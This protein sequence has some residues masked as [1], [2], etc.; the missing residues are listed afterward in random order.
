VSVAVGL[1]SFVPPSVIFTAYYIVWLMMTCVARAFAKSDLPSFQNIYNYRLS[2]LVYLTSFLPYYVPQVIVYAKDLLIHWNYHP[3]SLVLI[4]ED[5][6]SL[7]TLIYLV[8]I[9]K[10][11]DILELK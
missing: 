7:L 10:N 5:A 2:W 4:L 11:P 9:G 6:P 3:V 8:T 1:L